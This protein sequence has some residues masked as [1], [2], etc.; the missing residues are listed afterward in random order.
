M[1]REA[2]CSPYTYAADSQHL[3]PMHSQY[4]C[5]SLEAHRQE[6]LRVEHHARRGMHACLH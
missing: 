2:Y 4:A 5:T 3:L 1:T 6:C